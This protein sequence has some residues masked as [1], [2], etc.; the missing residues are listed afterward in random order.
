MWRGEGEAHTPPPLPPPSGVRRRDATKRRRLQLPVCQ[1]ER[2][3]SEHADFRW[4][5]TTHGPLFGY[6]YYASLC[7]TY[8]ITHRYCPPASHIAPVVRIDLLY[9]VVE[10]SLNYF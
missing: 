2:A 6:V 10:I 3:K 9:F 1:G 7:I 8:N 5:H 4:T